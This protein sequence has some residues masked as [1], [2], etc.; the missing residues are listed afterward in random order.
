MASRFRTAGFSGEQLQSRRL[1]AF[2]APTAPPP[3]ELAILQ[4]LQK[5]VRCSQLPERGVRGLPPW[6]AACV[7]ARESLE[8]VVIRV[9]S[10]DLGP[11]DFF[12]LYAAQQPFHVAFLPLTFAQHEPPFGMD[13]AAGGESRPAASGLAWEWSVKTHTLGST[14]SPP[15]AELEDVEVYWGVEYL[16]G[17]RL[18]TE[19]DPLPL[20]AFL[21]PEAVRPAP[22]AHARQPRSTADASLGQF[23]LDRPWLAGVL[24][25]AEP[26]SVPPGTPRPP[27]QSPVAPPAGAT[28]PVPAS[29]AP[30]ELATEDEVQTL[31]EEAAALRV[32]WSESLKDQTDNDFK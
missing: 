6:A 12:F 21:P 30:A 28:D 25:R 7:R 22:Q 5:G 14:F 31:L 8:K 29:R 9:N 23:L 18:G 3:A 24:P 32:A 1:R 13:P 20:R 11:R 27:A 15:Q 10:A 26:S 19:N 4:E 2:I 16:G 17:G